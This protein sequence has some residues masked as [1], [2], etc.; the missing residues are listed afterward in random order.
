MLK[1]G[2]VDWKLE[3]SDSDAVSNRRPNAMIPSKLILNQFQD[4]FSEHYNYMLHTLQK[5]KDR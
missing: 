1:L 3:I 2:F 4:L 5:P